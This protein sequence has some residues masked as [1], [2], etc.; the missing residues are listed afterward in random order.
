MCT[1]SGAE[2]NRSA[3]VMPYADKAGPA[4]REVRGGTK[5][6]NHP[7]SETE[8]EDPGHVKPK[9]DGVEPKRATDLSG[10]GKPEWLESRT[11]IGGSDRVTP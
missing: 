8:V 6:S 11:S 1:E 10:G 7:K 3:Q 4:R 5:D 2:G 9:A